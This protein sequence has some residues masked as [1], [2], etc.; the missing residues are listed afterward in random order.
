M[1]HF[2]MDRIKFLKFFLY[3]TD[4]TPQNGP[5]CYV[6]KS[7]R[8]LP[9]ELRRDG[10]F[11]DEEIIRSFGKDSVLE[12][13]APKGTLFAI[14]TRGLHK[15]IPLESGN[16][17][18]FQIEFANSMFGQSYPQLKIESNESNQSILE[19]ISEFPLVY[20]PMFDPK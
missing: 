6:E 4:V 5:H 19:K 3:L 1:F 8:N 17:L 12:L 16:R 15:G 7:H 18:I 13:C 11:K 10:R 20:A 14:D 2:D 9:T